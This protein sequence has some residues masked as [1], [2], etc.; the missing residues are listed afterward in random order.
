[1][2]DKIPSSAMQ[3]CLPA[4]VI[5]PIVWLFLPPLVCGEFFL[6]RDAAHYYHPLFQYVQEQWES[7]YVPLWNSDENSGQ[8]LAADVTASVFYPGKIV[9]WL[10][11]SYE[12][13]FLVYVIGHYLIG[14]YGT[15][16]LARRWKASTIGAT[17]SAMSYVFS[18][19]V[20][21]QYSNVVYLVSAVWLPWSLMYLESLLRRGGVTRAVQWGMTLSLMVLGG[22]PQS[23]V[24]TLLIGILGGFYYRH[25]S[26]ANRRLIWQSGS[27]AHLAAGVT[28][29]A[30]VSAV[31]WLPS[32]EWAAWT[33]RCTPDAPRSI[34]EQL[35][36]PTP[37]GAWGGTSNDRNSSTQAHA[38]YRFSIAPWRWPEVF[39]PNFSGKSF[40]V[41]RRW[42]HIVPAEGQTWSP[43]LYVG[44]VP[45]ILCYFQ[46][47]HGTRSPRHRWIR[48]VAICSILASLGWYG[49]GWIVIEFA[50]LFGWQPAIESPVGGVYWFLS[51]LVPGYGM[52]RYPAKWW[53][54]VTL[55]ISLAAGWGWN[56]TVRH[57]HKVRKHFTVISVA[58]MCVLALVVLFYPV[59]SRT[60]SEIPPSPIWGPLDACGAIEDLRF[61]LV[62]MIAVSWLGMISL[63]HLRNRAVILGLLFVTG[64]DLCW[65]HA[66]MIPTAPATLLHQVPQLI[67]DIAIGDTSGSANL[68]DLPGAVFDRDDNMYP[69][70]WTSHSSR[71]RLEEVVAHERA[72]LFPKYNLRYHL[73]IARSTGSAVPGE[74]ETLWQAASDQGNSERV[75]WHRLVGVDRVVT[76]G[77]PA[78]PTPT[79]V[80]VGGAQPRAWIVHKVESFPSESFRV[81][82]NRIA[83]WLADEDRWRTIALLPEAASHEA[84][85]LS[86]AERPESAGSIEWL[87]HR[88]GDILLR[89]Q[90]DHPGRLILAEFPAPGWRA[91]DERDGKNTQLTIVPTNL[92]MQSVHL[93][94]GS[95]DVHFRYEPKSFRW[96]FYI[97]TASLAMAAVTVWRT[98]HRRTLD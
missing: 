43:S 60:L 65:T 38:Q 24:H 70:D 56:L 7:G 37:A 23:A 36:M 68:Y 87:A 59:L 1:M 16:R 39:W 74:V 76:C 93:E 77:G 18:G 57:P 19:H 27:W 95:H 73:R 78:A 47:V 98:D 35:V 22:D 11:L 42:I 75:A 21:F 69:P 85:L 67:R 61:S 58:S 81:R 26:A 33:N 62:Q 13:R 55:A 90:L 79:W 32:L 92:V 63:R 46:F 82:R 53:A 50:T 4:I 15:Y 40:P 29:A 88:P 3:R 9:F 96:G 8:P 94:S 28:V 80:H 89:V 34:W 66:W 2:S 52:F 44:L 71:H 91:V 25:P 14:L 5:F 86:A 17:F 6:Y 83:S 64:A 51:S 45:A 84:R 10:P 12:R 20:I 97:T 31:Q 41:N 48:S 49:A 72:T 54:F 30:G